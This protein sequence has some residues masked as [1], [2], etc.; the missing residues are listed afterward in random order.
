MTAS[1]SI[2]PHQKYM[3]FYGVTSLPNIVIILCEILRKERVVPVDWGG[4]NVSFNLL[5]I[6][7]IHIMMIGVLSNVVIS[8]YYFIHYLFYPAK[9]IVNVVM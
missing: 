5:Y 2:N 4:V 1:L 3:K 7:K 9:A 8:R 6:I